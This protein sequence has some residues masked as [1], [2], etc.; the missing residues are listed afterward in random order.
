LS[1]SQG[2]SSSPQRSS[3]PSASG[4]STSECA[5]RRSWRPKAEPRRAKNTPHPTNGKDATRRNAGAKW[6]SPN[7][8]PPTTGRRQRRSHGGKKGPAVTVCQD[9]RRQAVAQPLRGHRARRHKKARANGRD[10]LSSRGTAPL[11]PKEGLSGPPVPIHNTGVSPFAGG[12][13]C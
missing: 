3:G 5:G 4:S 10:T 2:P 11:K 12:D 13:V 7:E 8:T 6:L 9:A 1:R